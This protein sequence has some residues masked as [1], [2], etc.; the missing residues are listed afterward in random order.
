M[1]ENKTR[2]FI[3]NLKDN[4]DLAVEYL[5]G[6]KLFLYEKLILN[7]QLKFHKNEPLYIIRKA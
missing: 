3:K 2:E 6:R 4:P 7:I 1:D 5:I